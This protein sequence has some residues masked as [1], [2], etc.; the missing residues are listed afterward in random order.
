MPNDTHWGTPGHEI[1]AQT[2]VT[3][4]EPAGSERQRPAERCP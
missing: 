4:F 2:I 1:V 3:A